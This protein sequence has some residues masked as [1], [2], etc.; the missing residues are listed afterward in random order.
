MGTGAGGSEAGGAVRAVEVSVRRRYL[1]G[2]VDSV[3]VAPGSSRL[4]MGRGQDAGSGRLAGWSAVWADASRVRSWSSM[5][6][7]LQRH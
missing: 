5:L 4:G 1:S 7:E 6:S 3:I 2:S